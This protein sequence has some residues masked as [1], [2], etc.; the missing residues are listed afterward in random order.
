MIGFLINAVLIAVLV[1]VV[2]PAIPQDTPR[3]YVLT[4]GFIFG[5][6]S[7]TIYRLDE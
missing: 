1:W 5:V 4:V 2:H 7:Q 6:I 3:V